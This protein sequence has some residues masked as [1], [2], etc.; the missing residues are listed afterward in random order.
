[1]T[2]AELHANIA[3]HLE[4][5]ERLLPRAYKLTLVVRCTDANSLAEADIVL[6]TDSLSAVVETL[7][8]KITHLQVS[9]AN[10]LQRG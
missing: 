4:S 7:T 9:A 10:K 8:E 5:I 3:P 6:T 2:V 1:M